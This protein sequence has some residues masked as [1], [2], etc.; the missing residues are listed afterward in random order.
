MPRGII[1]A[2]LIVL[3]IL[4]VY[5]VYL[6]VAG[7]KCKTGAD[8]PPGKTCVAGTCIAAT[9]SCGGGPPCAS[10]AVCVAGVCV[11]PPTCGNGPPC[12][13]GQSCQGGRCVAS[14]GGGPPC[15]AGQVC[16]GGVCGNPAGSCYA[17][18]EL[19]PA[20][21]A[22]PS[23]AVGFGAGTALLPLAAVD[24]AGNWYLGGSRPG[25]SWLVN[26]Y[27]AGANGAYSNPT[28]LRLFYLAVVS[29]CSPTPGTT[30]DPSRAIALNGMPVCWNS[31]ASQ[32]MGLFS[33][34]TAAGACHQPD[35]MGSGG[36]NF[37]MMSQ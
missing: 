21:P 34:A 3:L 35:S 25:G 10:P 1:I 15:P 22:A 14:C 9:S 19:D 24:A 37:Q 11:A 7:S 27:G 30:T 26:F 36:F 23:N 17:W 5:A 29:G 31:L 2:V 4:G 33:P 28:V 6:A 16:V 32:N 13:A 20:S 8:C 12:A 18:V